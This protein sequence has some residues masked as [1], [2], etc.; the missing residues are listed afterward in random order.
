MHPLVAPQN[1]QSLDG[2]SPGPS[3][4]PWPFSGSVVAMAVITGDFYG[5]RHILFLW[6]DLLVL[7][8]CILG[9]NCGHQW[10]IFS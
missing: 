10:N 5:R 7:V 3:V 8:A 6:G 4:L 9:H 2:P 1:P